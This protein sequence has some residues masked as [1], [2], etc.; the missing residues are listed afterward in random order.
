MKLMYKSIIF[1][2]SFTLIIAGVFVYT[3]QQAKRQSYG[4]V[5]FTVD[6][7][8]NNYSS[9]N[10]VTVYLNATWTGNVYFNFS[11]DSIYDGFMMIY[12]GNSSNNLSKEIFSSPK[13]SIQVDTNPY[14]NYTEVSD[15]YG[16]G[17]TYGVPFHIS[18]NEPSDKI[19]WN[20][21]E[22]GNPM[23][24]GFYAYY[25]FDTFGY[26]KYSKLSVELNRKYVYI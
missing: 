17:T 25:F 2:I 4:D 14:I 18:N 16:A 3:E 8:S 5:I 12:L 15:I 26:P 22:I 24:N 6:F 13:N 7:V 21:S 1:F 20:I 10:N 9:T 23:K 19:I 11:N